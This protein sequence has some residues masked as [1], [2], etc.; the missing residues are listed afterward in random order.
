[1]VDLVELNNWLILSLW[2]TELQLDV[3]INNSVCNRSN[4]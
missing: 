2:L 1:M 3:N 4:M